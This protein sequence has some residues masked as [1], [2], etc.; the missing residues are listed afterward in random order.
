M[1]P[2]TLQVNYRIIGELGIDLSL[3]VSDIFAAFRNTIY[4]KKSKTVNSNIE[5]FN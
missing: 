4:S 5:S 1:T 3:V 2:G